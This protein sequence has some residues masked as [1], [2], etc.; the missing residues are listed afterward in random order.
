MAATAPI[1]DANPSVAEMES[2]V[3]RF[4][5]LRPTADYVDSMI[6]GCE[7][8]R[9]E[10]F[11]GPEGERKMLLGQWDTVSIPPGVSR[12]FRNVSDEPAYLL[13]MASGQDPGNQLALA[14]AGCRT[15]GRC[16]S[17]VMFNGRLRRLLLAGE[18]NVRQHGTWELRKP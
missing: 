5:D 13:G 1:T 9:W 16:R 11:W 17:P 3:A 12:G 4:R 10:V 18:P 15:G 2:P 14:G 7:R 6:P 8:R